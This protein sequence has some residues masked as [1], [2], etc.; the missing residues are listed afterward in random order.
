[1]YHFAH[2]FQQAHGLTPMCYLRRARLERAIALLEAKE[3]SVNEVAEQVGLSRLA[4]WRGVRRLRGVAPRDLAGLAPAA[5]SA[6][7]A[8]GQVRV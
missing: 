5:Q 6:D 3:L 8:I 7:A 1:M 2:V 4:L